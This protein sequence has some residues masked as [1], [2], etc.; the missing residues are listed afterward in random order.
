MIFHLP[1]LLPR[2][3]FLARFF[4]RPAF[5][6]F[7]V[8]FGVLFALFRFLRKLFGRLVLLRGRISVNLSRLDFVSRFFFSRDNFF[9]VISFAHRLCFLLLWSRFLLSAFVW[10]Q[11][12]GLRFLLRLIF[13]GGILLCGFFN[14]LVSGWGLLGLL[15]GVFATFRWTLGLLCNI[16]LFCLFLRSHSPL[17]RL[18]LFA[19]NFLRL[20]LHFKFLLSLLLALCGAQSEKE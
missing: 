14:L 6:L 8:V 3:F 12:L 5:N 17:F 7:C 4:Q 2:F 19:G 1:S 20:R 13:I 18:F 9:L 15:F 11:L 16:G 10:L